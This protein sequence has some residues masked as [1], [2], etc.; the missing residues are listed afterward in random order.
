MSTE[1]K[2]V[3]TIPGLTKEQQEEM[4][5]RFSQM[6]SEQA[7]MMRKRLESMSPEQRQMMVQKMKEMSPEERQKL[8]EKIKNMSPEEKAAMSR[9]AEM[10]KAMQEKMAQMQQGGKGIAKPK[11]FMPGLKRLFRYV[12]KFKRSVIAAM[13]FAI[14]GTGCNLLTP[15]ML[16]NVLDALQNKLMNQTEINFARVAMFLGLLGMYYVLY[17][18]FNLLQSTIMTKVTQKTLFQMR[19]DVEKKIMKL[20]FSYFDK[21]S[22]GDIL[23]R[24]TN[25]ID[26]IGTSL[27][28]VITQSIVYVITIIGCFVF[29]FI[30]NPILTV[31]CILTVPI[32]IFA[33]K[34]IIGKSQNYFRDQMKAMGTINGAVEEHCSG[35]FVVKA[36]GY[37]EEAVEKFEAQNEQLFAVSKKAQFLSAVLNPISTMINN[38]T[39]T[40]ICV[41]GSIFVIKGFLTLGGITALIQY[42][43]QYSTPISQLTN[44]MNTLQSAVASA[45]RVFELLDEKEEPIT[46]KEGSVLTDVKGE[47]AFEHLQFG[48]TSDKLL[49]NDIN[50]HVKAGQKV[51]IVGPTGA[52]KTTLVNLLMRFY[53]I[54][55][56]KITI[57]GVDTSGLERSEIRKAIGM[58][59]QDTWLFHGSIKD[60]ISYGKETVTEEDLRK[61]A[62]ASQIDYFVKTMP[63]GFDSLINEDG[64]NISQGQK[65]LLTI[66]RAMIAD[67]AIL[68]LDEATSS[69]DTRTEAIIQGAMNKLMEGRT[70]FVIAHRLSTI[71]DA[72][73]ILV[74]KDGNIVEQGNHQ[75]L[76]EDNGLYADLYYSQF[77]D[78][79]NRG[80]YYFDFESKNNADTYD[81]M[82]R[83]FTKDTGIQVHR[84]SAPQKEYEIGL[85]EAMEEDIQPTF[86][87]MRSFTLRNRKDFIDYCADLSG[88]KLFTNL[89]D[90]KYAT[91]MEG[92]ALG[93]PYNVEGHGL[94]Y[95][96]TITRKY[97]AL[98]DKAVE[99]SN[100]SEIRDFTTF[101]A[102]VEDMTKHKEELGID[103]VYPT[104]AMKENENFE[105]KTH[106]MN[107]PVHYEYKKRGI[108]TADQFEF[109]YAENLKN[110]YDLIFNNCAGKPEEFVNVGM[111]D[112]IRQF[113]S[114]KVVMM[115]HF[116]WVW[117]M[118]K[119]QPMNVVKEED[120]KVMPIYFGAEGEAEQGISIDSVWLHSINKN[121]PKEK[122]EQAIQ[123]MEWLNFTETGRQY[124][125][126]LDYILPYKDIP[127]EE[128]PEGVLTRQIIEYLLDSSKRNMEFDYIDI[129]NGELRDE[130][131]RNVLAYA[132]GQL[133]WDEVVS[134]FC[135]SWPEM[136]IKN[137][138]NLL[139]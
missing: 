91:V 12:G 133:E 21:Q 76:L 57:D 115:N 65:Q 37:E 40:L 15:W 11:N 84:E 28:Q 114:G 13:L 126:K 128:N 75:Q 41:I 27:Q 50:V 45:E 83:R 131:G 43:K 64:S 138:Q 110:L 30:I 102:V 106:L 9:N 112:A 72:D 32:S 62:E 85:Q 66:A 89:L 90:P 116:Q 130:Y 121:A 59:L 4:E 124:I 137:Q 82:F 14:L 104:C 58:V 26:N 87:K 61:V 129:P 69:V 70:S 101:K 119:R 23:S 135:Q 2:L 8:Q 51:A 22:K 74:M 136:R 71:K 73:M 5:K 78:G 118:L 6:P 20:P 96:E 53:D 18:I 31:V 34:K 94:L 95:N 55:G 38:F 88:T 39:Y 3:E 105:W 117:N 56:G 19:Q 111:I 97:F 139:F 123:F 48:Y 47:I 132:L 103:G 93:V 7:E 68:I 36:F 67:P 79:N 42:Q 100:M 60:N 120:I 109:Q 92:H 122:Q 33:S 80:I 46:A 54:S 29:M 17:C 108:K 10:Q 16:S 81:E 44:L 25:D 134:K 98:K 113:A 63:E 86:F 1:K 49:M 99:I 77:S 52:G 125:R 107:L 127:Y 24:V 35:L